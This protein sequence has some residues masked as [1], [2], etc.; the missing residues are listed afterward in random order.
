MSYLFSKLFGGEAQYPLKVVMETRC[1]LPTG[2]IPELVKTAQKPRHKSWDALATFVFGQAHSSSEMITDALQLY[3]QALLELRNK[4]SNPDDWHSDRTLASVTALCMHEVSH[5]VVAL[6]KVLTSADIS[7]SDRKKL[8]VARRRSCMAFEAERSMATE[9]ICREE[10]LSPAPCCASKRYFNSTSLMTDITQVAKSIITRQTTFLYDPIWKTAPWEEDPASKSAIDY[11]VDI[12]TD[13]ADYISRIETC[14]RRKSNQELEYAQLR[15]QLAAPLK[16]S[17]TWWRQWEAEHAHPAI[18]VTSHQTF[19]ESLF[20]TVLEYDTL[21]T[22][23]TVYKLDAIR[24]L[25]LQLWRMLQLRPGSSRT[26]DPGVILDVPNTT[27][28]LGITSDT[29]GLACEILRS[30]EYSYRTS[31][32]FLYTFSFLFIQ[33]VAYGCFDRDSE[34]AIWITRH[35][36]ADFAECDD[37]GDANLLKR[38]VPSKV[39]ITTKLF[40]PSR[41]C[42]SLD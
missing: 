6:P 14:D 13:I 15:T 38:R 40:N 21:W 33:G 37:I 2:W 3:G 8:D 28:L 1:G 18:E 22:S 5:E 17:N 23:F 34:E 9:V 26:N 20:P 19:S 25:L 4:L 42:R 31:R 10:H 12:G 39:W 32:C 24:I 36:W 30:L 27:A 11:L 41:R 7:L 35:G 16:E 29:K